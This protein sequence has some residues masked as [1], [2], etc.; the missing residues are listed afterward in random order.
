MKSLSIVFTITGLLLTLLLT[1]VLAAK[2]EDVRGSKDHPMFNRMPGFVIS[3][4]DEREFDSYAN[5]RDPQG[6]K[7]TVEGNH[8]AIT[9]FL[10]KGQKQ[11][12]EAQIVKNFE[13]AVT[14]AGGE[15]VFTKRSQAYFRV[16][17]AGNVVWIYLRA[18]N[19]GRSY[20]LH[21]IEEA[22]MRQDIVVDADA[23]AKEIARTGKVSLYGI[24][25]DTGK[26]V[27]KPESDPTIKE[28]AT[29]LKKNPSFL[30]YVVG[31]TDGTGKFGSNLAL[32]ERRAQAVKEA[33]VSRHGIEGSRLSAHGVGPLAPAS[34]NDTSGGR[35]KNRRTELVKQ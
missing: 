29:L 21:V 1:G 11:P 34:T 13:D 18:F 3:T 10:K 25:F 8:T 22:A 6:K 15:V 2:G 5:F 30:L 12:G 33:L 28:V 23:M 26:A 14:S 32:S 7:T 9:Y 16:E 19:R 35:S 31:H 4:Y 27:L 20:E 17:D 24:F